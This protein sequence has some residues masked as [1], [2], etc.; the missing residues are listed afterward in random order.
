MPDLRRAWPQP[1]QNRYTSL[2]I[3]I[4]ANPQHVQTTPDIK[5]YVDMFVPMCVKY[6]GH[7][8]QEV[9]SDLY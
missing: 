6:L 4:Q 3:A 9:N 7:D 2:R 8:I 5:H 1:G